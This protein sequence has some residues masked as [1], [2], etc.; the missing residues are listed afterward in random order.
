MTTSIYAYQK[1]STPYT[2]IAA[3]LPDSSG[4][5]DGVHC[6]ELCTLD[7]TTYLA[8][9]D[10][11]TLPD[12]PPEITL[13]PVTLTPELR[14]RIKAN[15]VHCDL[16]AERMEQRIRAVYSLSDE[17]YFSRIGVG[18]ALGSYTFEPGEQAALMAFG[19]HVEGARQWGRAE[20]AK[21]GL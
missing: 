9:P 21:L 4:V 3:S 20:R 8:V 13:A 1:V 12:Q 2:I 7:G 10:G 16:I 6:T 17:Q 18:V 15:S 19:A 11:V 14:S 5:D